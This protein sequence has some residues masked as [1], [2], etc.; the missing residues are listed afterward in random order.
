MT[1][2]KDWFESMEYHQGGYAIELGDKFTHLIKGKGVIP[3]GM[4]NGEI[5]RVGDA[6]YALDLK[7][8]LL[9][10]CQMTKKLLKIKFEPNISC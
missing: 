2:Q 7:K 1:S 10:V 3:I 5:K 8:N 4:T 9:S 6:L